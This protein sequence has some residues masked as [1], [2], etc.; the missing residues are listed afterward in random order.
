[1]LQDD[2]RQAGGSCEE[3]EAESINRYMDRAC[4]GNSCVVYVPEP[5]QR[6]GSVQLF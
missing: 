3:K 2:L 4:D 6:D 5:E 1:M